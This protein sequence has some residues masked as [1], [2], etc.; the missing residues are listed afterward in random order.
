MNGT[1]ATASRPFGGR[2]VKECAFSSSPGLVTSVGN[3]IA[4]TNPIVE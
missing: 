1:L 4:V 2:G 3:M